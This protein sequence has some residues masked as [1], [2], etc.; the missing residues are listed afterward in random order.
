MSTYDR[1]RDPESF[2]HAEAIEDFEVRQKTSSVAS[3]IMWAIALVLSFALTYYAAFALRTFW[4]WFIEPAGA[5]PLS[6]T[7]SIGV[8][9][10][11]F[12]LKYMIA[13]NFTQNKGGKPTYYE[14]LSLICMTAFSITLSFGSAALWK[15]WV[16]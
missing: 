7:T 12:L 1:H 6:T 14:A 11:A 3:G 15:F 2:S 5:E 8:L 4:R 13:P 10:I 9:M 16:L